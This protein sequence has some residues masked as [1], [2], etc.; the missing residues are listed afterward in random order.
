MDILREVFVFVARSLVILV[1]VDVGLRTDP[2]A[3]RRCFALPAF[4]RGMLV[5]V[6]AVPLLA[7]AVAR[8]WPLGGPAAM[9][10]AL[11]G[12]APGH[13]MSIRISRKQHADVELATALSLSLAV[14]TILVVPLWALVL[15]AVFPVKLHLS[16]AGVAGTLALN[17]L[18]PFGL[19]LAARVISPRGA[20][21]LATVT[22]VLLLAAL[23]LVFVAALKVSAPAL[24]RVN[25]WVIGAMLV[26][27]LGSALMG[28]LAGGPDPAD[29]RTVGIAAVFGNP[30][31][32]LHI[33]ALSFPHTH[34]APIVLAYLLLRTVALIP[35]LAWSR[36]HA[37]G[38]PA[39]QAHS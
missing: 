4:R 28:H 37:R 30:A 33:A 20:R 13:P 8:F 25:G 11:M 29:R 39:S 15:N 32:A 16:V 18:L 1:M 2:A 34:A 35:Y 21:R 19:A 36:R 7:I 27:T 38:H 9:A 6:L 14:T 22:G 12:I 24:S 26:V 3:L 17:V 5:A 23:L 10:I 31:I